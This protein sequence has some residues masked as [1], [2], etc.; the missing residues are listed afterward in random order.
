[1][2]IYAK[3]DGEAIYKFL[4]SF[5]TDEQIADA[6][7]YYDKK[8]GDHAFDRMLSILRM[9]GGLD[10]CNTLGDDYFD[11]QAQVN[12]LGLITLKADISQGKFDDDDY[13]IVAHLLML[14]KADSRKLLSRVLETIKRE[15]PI[16][17]YD[18]E[19]IDTIGDF[20]DKNK[21]D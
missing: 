21:K 18:E 8:Y 12:V 5:V 9:N 15:Y 7:S 16:E 11:R 14:I 17:V 20:R 10:K 2:V 3:T 1:M 13:R 19:P 6:P 4:Q